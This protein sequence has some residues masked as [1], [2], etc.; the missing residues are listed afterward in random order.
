MIHGE[1]REF[2][3]GYGHCGFRYMTFTDSVRFVSQVPDWASDIHFRSQH[4]F[5]NPINLKFLGR[6]E[7]FNEDFS[8]VAAHLEPRHK[9]KSLLKKKMM[10]SRHR[11]YTFYY[12]EETKPLIEER[13][14][15]DVRMFS[16]KFGD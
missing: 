15:E 4:T 2:I 11:H 8:H 5:I 13:Y 12:N 14:R 9:I 16:Y 1:Y 3:R 6:L 10:S 7:N